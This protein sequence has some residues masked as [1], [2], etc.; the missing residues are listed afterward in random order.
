MS[1]YLHLRFAEKEQIP[2]LRAEGLSWSAIARWLGQH[3]SAITREVK[4]NALP[5]GGYQPVYAEGCYSSAPP[6][7]IPC[8]A[9]AHLPFIP[10]APSVP[11]CSRRLRASRRWRGD[12]LRPPLTATALGS[13]PNPQVGTEGWFADEQRDGRGTL[14]PRSCSYPHWIARRLFSARKRTH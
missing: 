8:P 1:G 2:G 10:T 9:P 6:E 7:A 3:P 11:P 4:R 14:N 12:G 13:L 5:S